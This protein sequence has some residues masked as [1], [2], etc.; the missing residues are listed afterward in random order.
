MNFHWYVTVTPKYVDARPGSDGKTYPRT[1]G[2]FA[3][4]KEADDEAAYQRNYNIHSTATVHTSVPIVPT[5]PDTYKEL[6]KKR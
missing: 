1:L 4:Q 6:L 5:W 3:T 2:P